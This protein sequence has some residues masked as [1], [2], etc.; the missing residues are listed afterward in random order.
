V[1][2]D[3]KC[4]RLVIALLRQPKRNYHINY[5]AYMDYVAIM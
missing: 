3:L 1:V 2:E 5:M 4:M